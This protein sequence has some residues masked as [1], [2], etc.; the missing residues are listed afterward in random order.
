MCSPRVRQK[1]VWVSRHD[2]GYHTAMNI[3]IAMATYNGAAYLVEQLDSLAKQDLIPFELVISDDLSTDTT[4]EIVKE[5]K[6]T[7]PF[8]VVILEN[9]ERLGYVANFLRAVAHCQGD[10]IS[11]CDQDDVWFAQKLA[12]V[13]N[14]LVKHQALM[15]IHTA[16]LTNQCLEPLGSVLPV[17]SHT[18]ILRP[19]RL[20]GGPLKTFP[21]GFCLT[22][23]RSVRDIV[24]PALVTYPEEYQHYFGHEQPFHLIS[25]SLGPV[26]YLT[27]PLAWYRR[28][29]NNASAGRTQESPQKNGAQE[30]A[31]YAHHQYIYSQ[32]LEWLADRVTAESSDT[33]YKTSQWLNHLSAIHAHHAQLMDERA[34]YYESQQI[35]TK[36]PQLFSL[37]RRSAYSSRARGG[38]GAK[39]LL[40][41]LAHLLR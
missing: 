16:R 9:Q 6:K 1:K 19:N 37:V 20:D 39:S 7:A 11:F 8:P 17:I 18:T 10:Y 41:D 5:F 30:Y 26:A 2:L 40:K 38:L 25:R 32:F 28:H 13:S 21:L 15:V 33:Q 24:I 34:A 29:E 12:L 27:T 23:H 3:S 31:A 14:T 36:V 4:L 22:F 35:T